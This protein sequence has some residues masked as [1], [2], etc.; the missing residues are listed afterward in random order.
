MYFLR[1]RL[2]NHAGFQTDF[3]TLQRN[4]AKLVRLTLDK[5]LA[6]IAQPGQFPV[7]GELEQQLKA[8]MQALPA[9]L[10]K[11]LSDQALARLNANAG[12]QQR[13]YG[14]FA[15]LPIRESTP[16]HRLAEPFSKHTQIKPISD[17]L[18]KTLEG[19]LGKAAA[20]NPRKKHVHSK[21]R[22]GRIQNSTGSMDTAV[23]VEPDFGLGPI[24]D[25]EFTD[26]EI[27]PKTLELRLLRVICHE[28]FKSEWGKDELAFAAVAHDIY[29]RQ[30]IKFAPHKLG[31]F[32]KGDNKPMND[33]LLAAIPVT[34]GAWRDATYTAS[35]YLAEKDLGGFEKAV[36]ELQGLS[37]HEM[38]D[39]F[40]LLQAV[41]LF[42]LL[43]LSVAA[44]KGFDANGL[45]KAIGIGLGPLVYCTLYMGIAAGF[46]PVALTWLGVVVL[47]KLLTVTGLGLLEAFG[48]A[49]KD[50]LFPPQALAFHFGVPDGIGDAG[51][52]D[53][54]SPTRVVKSFQFIQKGLRFGEHVVHYD[55]E[56]EWR[57][58][59]GV[60]QAAAPPPPARETE[61]PELALHNLDKI[62]HVGVV[63]L[64]NRSFHQ[65]LGFLANDRGRADLA[66]GP[67]T[68]MF[69]VLR[70]KTR[71]QLCPAGQDC[72][73]S[74]S[75][76]AFLGQDHRV[77]VTRLQNTA[78]EDDPGHA[79]SNA[80]RQ[81]F[82]SE[83]FLSVD[84]PDT[85]PTTDDPNDP[86]ARDGFAVDP[87]WPNEG[88]REL[89]LARDSLTESAGPD[90][91]SA[92]VG[93][94][95]D[96]FG[97][98]KARGNL[99][100]QRAANPGDA[101]FEA[102]IT[103]LQDIMGYYP[104]AAVPAFDLLATEFA[105]CDRWYSSYPG[106]TWVNRTL[107]LTGQPARQEDFAKD[108]R[109]EDREEVVAAL[110][111]TE[112]E[113]H[114]KFITDNDMPFDEASFF[115]ILDQHNYE[116]EAIHWAF[117]AQDM[118]SLL[119]VDAGYASE[120][121]NRLQGRPNRIRSL[122]RFF[123]DAAQGNLPH[124]FWVDPNFMDIGDMRENLANWDPSLDT[125]GYGLSHLYDL[126]TAND[127]HPPVD[128]A[129]GQHFVLEIFN[130]LFNSP[131][132]SKTLLI[133]VYD[134]H[135]GF[136][137]PVTPPYLA[138]EPESP[139]FRSLGV[140]VP[141]LVVSP[142]VGRQLVSHRRFDHISII[143]T[144]LLK[145]CRDA[146][147]NIPA[148]AG[149]RVTAETT[150]HLGHLLNESSPRFVENNV[151]Q[152]A[153]GPGVGS[154][155]GQ[156]RRA[157]ASISQAPPRKRRAFL[158]HVVEGT[159]VALRLRRQRDKNKARPSLRQPTELKSQMKEARDRLLA[160][161]LPPSRRS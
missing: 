69:N 146:N 127:D 108:I 156:A 99:V 41:S 70:A 87:H 154:N 157:Q 116:G 32:K 37:S 45:A 73:F 132:W 131:Q 8:K 147:G 22:I 30:D 105:V 152:G 142:W 11:R 145:F 9:G 72:R 71:D 2:A 124:V 13:H 149:P 44:E 55:L 78:I 123:K 6:H 107:S 50:D 84:N 43:G 97:V 94:V 136:F 14:I 46:W 23:G 7:S 60:G 153:Y 139:A 49:F 47:Y 151:V 3:E 5:V 100:L 61:D 121:R 19:E 89:P 20:E 27:Q 95:E 57:V 90:E 67:T 29:H 159:R 4:S 25:E 54:G 53:V 155:P 129:H 115:R 143:K 28:D 63:M 137:D 117:Y 110:K 161:S 109:K 51:S 118:P 106:N 144:I 26:V 39:L 158:G 68:N 82:A 133:I 62:E 85:V 86:L 134:E 15:S 140:R 79:V 52:L 12:E 1:K 10:R 77:P 114:A 74:E 104:A 65:M 103:Q 92:M 150:Q 18:K 111:G 120:F 93:F 76:L 36:D 125:D 80:E 126:N 16:I 21:A 138:T 42:S 101:E 83:R 40:V 102:Q 113:E 48:D 98:L 35:L 160:L 56:F 58:V 88:A 34:S 135:G 66:D 141:A 130:A 96:Y 119:A 17:R 59:P 75:A 81:I 33:L 38:R 122:D 24:L 148:A 128:I 112:H 91:R 64:E 31:K